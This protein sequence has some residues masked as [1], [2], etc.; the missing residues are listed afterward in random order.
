MSEGMNLEDD[1]PALPAVDP[2]PP[3][4]PTAEM[5]PA[6][7]HAAEVEA[8]E[9][10]GQKYVPLA[11]VLAERNEKKA[12][13]DRAS[14]ADAYEAELAQMRPYIQFLQANPQLLQPRTP[15]PVP[16]HQAPAEDPD[17]LEAAQMMDFYTSDGKPDVARGAKWLALQDRRNQR[18]TQEAVRPYAEQSQQERS[19]V[20][21]MRAA[22]IADADGRKPS[23]AA[24]REV[25]SNMPAELTSDPK[26]A[27]LLAMIA[28]GMDRVRTKDGPVAPP[29][30][31]PAMVTEASGGTPRVRQVMSALESRVAAERNI[32]QTNWMD[33]TKGFTANRPSVLEDD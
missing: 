30:P 32:N 21:F 14:K 19:Q 22:Q 6:D 5:P 9:V 20:N 23:E 13:K 26:V 2:P 12:L 29:V 33:R 27:G 17:A 16:A 7:Q 31:P 11:A 24:L 15:E 8:V 3:E 25:W 4:A 1:G 18:Q 10:G 28:F